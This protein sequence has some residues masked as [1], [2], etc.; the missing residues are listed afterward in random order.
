[1]DSPGSTEKLFKTLPKL[2]AFAIGEKDS[3]I[4]PQD[5]DNIQPFEIL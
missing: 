4:N 2:P 5:K 3:Q 1:M